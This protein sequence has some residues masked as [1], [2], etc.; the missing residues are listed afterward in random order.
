MRLK[1]IL[2]VISSIPNVFPA[3][4]NQRYITSYNPNLTPQ[5]QDAEALAQDWQRVGAYIAY[6]IKKSERKDKS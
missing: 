2:R 6:A 1:N 4:V 3:L 5:Q